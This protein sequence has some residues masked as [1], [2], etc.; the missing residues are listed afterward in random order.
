MNCLLVASLLAAAVSFTPGQSDIVIAP[1]ACEA[2]QVAAGS[3]EARRLALVRH[4][5]L[6]ELKKAIG[7]FNAIFPA[8]PPCGVCGKIQQES[9]SGDSPPNDSHGRKKSNETQSGC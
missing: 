3:L 9:L 5:T 4:E 1:D 6:D 2:V 8:S 7:D